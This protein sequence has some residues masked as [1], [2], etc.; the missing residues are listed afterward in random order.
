MQKL[1]PYLR[2]FIL[3]GT[4]FFIAKT[5][6][7]HWQEV[8]SIRVGAEAWG[9]LA[10]ALTITLL[11]HVWTGW[12]WGWILAGLNHPVSG[13]WSS[14]VYLQTNVAK[15][16]PG[17]VWHFYGRAWAAK[18]AGIPLE[19]ASLSVLL[20]PLLMAAAALIVA[21]VSSSAAYKGLQLL[22]LGV[23]LVAVHPRSLNPAIR[24][25]GRLKKPKTGVDADSTENPAPAIPPIQHY[26]FLPLLGELI[27]LGLRG[28]GFCFTVMALRAITWDQVPLLLGAFSVAWLL[29]LIIPGAPGGIGVFEA[30]AIALLDN[31]FP[32]AMVVSA[33][34]VYRLVSLLAELAGAG[35]AWLYSR[36]I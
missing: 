33:V 5:L 23:V 34:A 27:F 12:V 24:L 36:R 14:R 11:A 29:G 10:I 6:R 21:L 2:W 9:Y 35:I 32:P 19:I 22:G 26:P 17:N 16:L 4:L 30:T 15:Y 31:Y 13:F 28:A 8:A 18:A 1:K 7:D 25:V 3:G 20:E